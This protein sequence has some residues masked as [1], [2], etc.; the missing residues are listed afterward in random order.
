MLTDNSV[1]QLK[2]TFRGEVI[3]P[4][5]ASYDVAR[6]VFNG[7]IDRH[8]GIIVKCAD[9]T[10]VINAVNFGRDNN[11]LIAVRSGGHSA[12]GLGV[13][14]DGLVID[15][16]KIKYTHIDSDAETVLVGCGCTWGDVDHATNGFGF[17]TPSGMVS[18]TG[19]S[20]L[21]L[22]GGMGHLTRKFGL[23]IDNLLEADVVLANGKLVKAN[24]DLNQDLFW[25]I[26]G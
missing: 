5:D 8:P 6:K 21:T 2:S 25:A 24:K 10:D 19:V 4:G 12:G 3:L 15:L 14:D 17:V 13:C 22:G 26:R 23:T 20:G 16:S 1:N 9:V 7:M 18:T 11:L